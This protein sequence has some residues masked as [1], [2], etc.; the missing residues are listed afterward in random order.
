MEEAGERR[1]VHKGGGEGSSFEDVSEES[2]G[3]IYI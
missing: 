1:K 3:Y 2:A